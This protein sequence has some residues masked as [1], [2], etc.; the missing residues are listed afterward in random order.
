M[1]ETLDIRNCL[2]ARVCGLNGC[3]EVHH[4]LLHQVEKKCSTISASEHAPN[5]G[6][7]GDHVSKKKGNIKYRIVFLLKVLYLL[8]KRSLRKTNNRMTLQ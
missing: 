7:Q 3:L 2:R 5:N 8:L 1:R 4:R 6:S